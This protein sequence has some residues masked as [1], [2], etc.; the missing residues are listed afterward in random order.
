MFELVEKKLFP[1]MDIEAQV[2]ENKLFS[3]K[4]IHLKNNN[5]E[6]SFAVAFRTIPGSSNGVA[7][8]LE[9]LVLSGSKRYPVRGSFFEMMK[10]SLSSFM[11]AMTGSDYTIYPFST[12]NNKDFKN[13]LDVY[14]D[15]V[16]FPNLSELDFMQEGH[17]FELIKDIKGKEQLKINDKSIKKE[18]LFMDY[19]LQ[20]LI[21]MRSL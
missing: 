11:N 14:L 13:L 1:F 15:A 12:V 8:I 4:H 18:G 2:Y 16:F 10:R 5:N 17:R 19:I 6:K 3:C 7:H 21:L 9:H 20:N